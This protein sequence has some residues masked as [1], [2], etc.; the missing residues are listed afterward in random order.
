MW[1]VLL[2][3]YLIRTIY[4][5]EV[6][7]IIIAPQEEERYKLPVNFDGEFFYVILCLHTIFSDFR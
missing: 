2:I 4:N 7:N 1:K 5:D 6:L 3:G